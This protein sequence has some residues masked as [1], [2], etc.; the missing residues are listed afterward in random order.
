MNGK[1]QEPWR[2]S[3]CFHYMQKYDFI[4]S[5]VVDISDVFEIRMNAVKAFSSQFF[6]PNS[7]DPQTLLSQKSFLD[8]IETRIKFYGHQIGSEYGEPFYSVDPVGVSDIFSLK[9]FK[10]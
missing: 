6:D 7:K 3:N 2:P 5:F 1:A 9:I 4:P 10:E 8:F